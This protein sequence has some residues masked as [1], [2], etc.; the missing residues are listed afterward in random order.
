MSLGL[1]L[2]CEV[3]IK[4]YCNNSYSMKNNFLLLSK[5]FGL[6]SHECWQ[7]LV[8]CLSISD[9]AKL[10]QSL[11]SFWLDY[12]N[13]MPRGSSG[14]GCHHPCESVTHKRKSRAFYSN[15]IVPF[16][17]YKQKGLTKNGNI[18]SWN[19]DQ[20]GNGVTPRAGMS[21]MWWAIAMQRQHDK[22]R[23]L[24]LK[25]LAFYFFLDKYV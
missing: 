5:C 10:I 20:L 6:L 23:R 4:S 14:R 18:C 15:H 8:W 21:L 7:A 25:P 2:K 24:K 19:T 12:C 13:V 11:I 17:G 22:R 16:T 9:T 3:P 1:L